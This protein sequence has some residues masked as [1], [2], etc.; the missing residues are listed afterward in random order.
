MIA[1]VVKE[2]KNKKI[3]M[4]ETIL[5]KILEMEGIPN[6][7][8]PETE[9]LPE[10][11]TDEITAEP[12][13]TKS[14]TFPT[15][16]QLTEEKI[17]VVSPTETK[18]PLVFIPVELPELIEDTELIF[19]R[20]TKRPKIKP[21][22]SFDSFDF[23]QDKKKVKKPAEMVQ[24]IENATGGKKPKTLEEALRIAE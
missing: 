9:K 8:L 24:L 14:V 20:P 19:D 11:K 4:N 13:A 5:E 15:T 18:V 6:V 21:I 3:V 2:L 22:D 17:E 10:K 16:D 23:G 12:K 7:T 1:T